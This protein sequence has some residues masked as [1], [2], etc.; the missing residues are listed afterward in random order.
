MVE[1]VNIGTTDAQRFYTGEDH[2]F[3]LTVMNADQTAAINITGWAMSWL[4]KRRVYDQDVYAVI[5]KTTTGSPAGIEITDA[6]NG[7]C[8]IHLLSADTL[9]LDPRHYRHELIRTDPGTRTPLLG[10]LFYLKKAVHD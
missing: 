1:H 7:L 2:D 6:P 9:L 8:T 10:G 4:V 5:E 3:T